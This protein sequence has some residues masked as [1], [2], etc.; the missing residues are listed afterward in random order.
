ME[1]HS[2]NLFFPLEYS[3]YLS[4]S[5]TLA[6]ILHIVS[7]RYLSSPTC[8]TPNTEQS[9]VAPLKMSA[10]SD[11]YSSPQKS[12]PASSPPPETPDMASQDVS[13][14]MLKEEEQMRIQREKVDA[15]RDAKL[16]KE[17]EKDLKGGE[18]AVDSKFKA[19]EYLLNQSKVRY[20]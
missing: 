20:L 5:C 7:L 18:K 2:N 6:P 4:L 3:F 9:K 12:T 16:Q 10:S 14:S 17:V 15:K 8:G 13:E 11:T 1:L 19:L